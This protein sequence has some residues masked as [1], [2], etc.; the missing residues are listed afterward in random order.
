[1]VDISRVPKLTNTWSPITN[2]EKDCMV[3][4]VLNLRSSSH[5]LWWEDLSLTHWKGFSLSSTAT[6]NQMKNN[7]I[8]VSNLPYST[9]G[10]QVTKTLISIVSSG[11]WQSN[12]STVPTCI[13]CPTGL[14]VGVILH[15]YHTYHIL[16][17]TV[18]GSLEWRKTSL[19]LSPTKIWQ[20]Y[21]WLK[22]NFK[23]IPN[24]FYIKK[25]F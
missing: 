16:L 5:I 14:I 19:A 21:F 22:M 8:A 3:I 2:R 15:L 1:M 13:C 23:L 24:I 7:L 11:L 17:R 6:F 25:L 12:T 10:K 20:L 18:R 4:L 9:M